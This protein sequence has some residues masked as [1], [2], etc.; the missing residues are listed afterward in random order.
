MAFYRG[1]DD[2][3]GGVNGKEPIVAPELARKTG[4]VEITV[5]Q[6]EAEKHRS[7]Q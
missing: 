5:K 4:R 7:Q 3:E 2:C 1:S 6:S